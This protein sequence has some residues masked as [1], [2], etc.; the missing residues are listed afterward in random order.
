MHSLLILFLAA[1]GLAVAVPAPAPQPSG[2]SGTGNSPDCGQTQATC[3]DG[4][5]EEG[6]TLIDS[7]ITCLFSK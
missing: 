5:S 3:C 4:F 6:G 1:G 2:L 7:C